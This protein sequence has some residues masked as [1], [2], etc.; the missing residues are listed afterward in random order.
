[1]TCTGTLTPCS[2][3]SPTQCSGVPGCSLQ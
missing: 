2:A 3:L 1:V